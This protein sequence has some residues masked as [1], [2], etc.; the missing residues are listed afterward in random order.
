MSWAGKGR[1][2]ILPPTPSARDHLQKQEGQPQ[3]FQRMGTKSC[4][5]EQNSNAK[6]QQPFQEAGAP[7]LPSGGPIPRWHAVSTLVLS[8]V[9][10]FVSC[11]W[12]SV[13]ACARSCFGARTTR[14]FAWS[15]LLVAVLFSTPSGRSAFGLQPCF[16]L[17]CRWLPRRFTRFQESCGPLRSSFPV[18]SCIYGCSSPVY[19]RMH[20]HGTSQSIRRRSRRSLRFGFRWPPNIFLQVLGAEL[21][22]VATCP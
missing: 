15:C 20:L 2:S 3:P 9:R 12:G 7:G 1:R 19:G 18:C 16:P 5:A 21:R 4:C 10:A 13:L 8:C 6:G 14:A 17:V 11:S 22:P